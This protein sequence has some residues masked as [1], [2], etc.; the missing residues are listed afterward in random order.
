MI[1]FFMP[2]IPPKITAQEKDITFNKKGKPI[3]YEPYELAEA[4]EKLS[5]HLAQYVPDKM[6]SGAVQ[7]TT[8]WLFPITGEHKNGEYKTTRPDTD[9]LQ[10]ML[11]DCMTKVGYW[12]DDA[13]V[14][15]EIS[16][17]FYADIPGIYIRIT[18]L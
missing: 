14:A 12:K 6:Y 11:K 9:N 4:R 16:E 10:K 5:A 3:V 15:S 17:K 7:L 1:E 8:K 2:M 13:L 18:K